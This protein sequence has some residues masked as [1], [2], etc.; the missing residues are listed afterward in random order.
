MKTF[1]KNISS[2]LPLSYYLGTPADAGI[3]GMVIDD[4]NPFQACES[5]S[6]THV[7]AFLLGGVDPN[8]STMRGVSLL[9]CAAKAGQGLIARFLIDNGADVNAQ[10]NDGLTALMY[11]AMAGEIDTIKML[12]EGRADPSLRCRQQHSCYFYAATKPMALHI[13][14]TVAPMTAGLVEEEEMLHHV[15]DTAGNRFAALYLIESLGADPNYK[16]RD[17]ASTPL[18]CAVLTGD[19]DLVKALVSKG[20]D[21]TITDDNGLRPTALPRCP[22]HISR[23]IKKYLAEP[24]QTRRQLLALPD[25][26][27]WPSLT[28][29]ELRNCLF[30]LTV[31]H[32]A[33]VVGTYIHP[34]FSLLCFFCTLSVF[35]S[36]ASFSLKQKN[37]SLVTAGFYFGGMLIGLTQFYAKVVPIFDEDN[38][39]SLCT[40]LA[41]LFV[42]IAMYTYIRAILADPGCVQSTAEQRK[43]FYAVC[44]RAGER[45]HFDQ[46]AMVRKPLRSKHCSKTHQSVKRFDHYCVW[47]GNAVG[48]GNH[49]YFILFCICS[50]I[51][52][53]FIS[54]EVV[55]YYLGGGAVTR[56]LLPG[57]TFSNVSDVASFL[58]ADPNILVTYFCIFYNVFVIMFTGIM[59]ATQLGMIARNMTSNEQWFSQ[60]YTWL[61]TLGS[62]TYN[63]FDEGPWN[64]FKNFWFG[65]LGIEVY[66]NPKMSPYLSKKVK[67]YTAK[68]KKSQGIAGDVEAPYVPYNPT[69]AALSEAPM[70]ISSQLPV[71]AAQPSITLDQIPENKQ[72]EVSVIQMLFTQLLQGNS[73]PQAPE[74]VALSAER[75]AA[76]KLQ[77][78]SMLEKYRA[79]MSALTKEATGP[80]VT[81]PEDRKRN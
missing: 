20:A 54:R 14:H 37:R 28:A 10:D 39:G 70:P 71:T 19:L 34:L 80:S 79:R 2:P 36:V 64:N 47:T 23:W 27:N 35:G 75:I 68:I 16:S 5:G 43:D 73:D 60:R 1:K 69:A 40:P 41:T 77:A 32:W 62:T 18:H 9:H 61:F 11:A 51:G 21:P 58:F 66:D 31:P 76:C 3:E 65:D 59:S 6:F 52:H 4:L 55:Y 50:A 38:P 25:F 12:I 24:S 53:A 17:K 67:E 22:R 57:S 46:T 13:L 30:Y 44:H 48:S 56:Q 7:S 29:K 74:G 33:I 78:N 72:L 42:G 45:E 63:M 15:S 81:S 49:R 8:T 26:S